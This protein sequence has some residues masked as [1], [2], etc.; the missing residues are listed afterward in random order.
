MKAI[1]I[2]RRLE[3]YRKGNGISGGDRCLVSFQANSRLTAAAHGDRCAFQRC[4]H[5][6]IPTVYTANGFIRLGGRSNVHR[7]LACSIGTYSALEAG[8][9][10]GG[11]LNV[12]QRSRAADQNLQ[13][14]H[15]PVASAV[16][17]KCV[18]NAFNHRAG[19][20]GKALRNIQ[21]KMKAIDI[22]RRLEIYRKGNSI[23]RV[24]RSLVSFHRNNGL[25]SCMGM[26]C[27]WHHAKKNS[28]AQQQ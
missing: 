5:I 24:D 16:S 17:T 15:F 22:D 25:R 12:L 9:R 4:I 14:V 27:C 23:P 20:I 13:A 19:T 11:I 18:A 21:I 10:Q 1:D 8:D 3:I 28:Q 26:H 6:A 7:Q 2:D